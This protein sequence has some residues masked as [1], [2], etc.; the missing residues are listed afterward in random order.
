MRKSIVSF[1]NKKDENNENSL[2]HITLLQNWLLMSIVD[3]TEKGLSNVDR[4]FDMR[5]VRTYSVKSSSTL[6][7]CSIPAIYNRIN[8]AQ[9]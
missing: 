9:K 7:S 1:G 4:K 6:F 3:T 5:K 8:I 2:P